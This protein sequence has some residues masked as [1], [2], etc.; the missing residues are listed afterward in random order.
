[1][2]NV[3]A[4]RRSLLVKSIAVVALCLFVLRGVGFIEMVASLA[5]GPAGSA[6]ASFLAM[7]AGEKCHSDDKKTDPARRDHSTCCVS[8]AWAR[9]AVLLDVVIAAR[10]LDLFPET[11]IS[12]PAW[13]VDATARAPAPGLIANWSATSPPRSKI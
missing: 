11:H 12:L 9:D 10:I 7:T 1:M 6:K 4:H 5:A 2:L 3:K 8:C 13:S